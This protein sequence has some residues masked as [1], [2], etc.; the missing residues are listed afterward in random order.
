MR[1]VR[2]ARIQTRAAR[3]HMN[4]RYRIGYTQ[5]AS[6]H[7]DRVICYPGWQHIRSHFVNMFL[8]SPIHRSQG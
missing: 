4:R 3:I 5:S 7:C 6:N 8:E 2:R 1:K